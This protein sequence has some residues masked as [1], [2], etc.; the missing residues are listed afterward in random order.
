MP[1]WMINILVGFWSVLAEMSPYLLFG[2]FMAGVL[3]ILISPSLVERHLGSRGMW[4]IIK[5]AA[6]GI[7]LPLCSCGVIP[8]S[9][10]LRRHGASRGATT[11]FLISTP[12]DGVDSI[13][14]AYGLLGGVYAIFMPIV[15]LVTG[16]T[17]GILVNIVDRGDTTPDESTIDLK[18]EEERQ[19]QLKQGG[20]GERQV[21]QDSRANL[22]G[23][24][25]NKIRRIFSY[26]FITMPNDIGRALI[27]G[28]IIAALISAIIPKDY[29][30]SIVSPGFYRFLC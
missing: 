28:L 6:F 27:V 21:G 2:F 4:S 8:V 30:S 12:Q 18:G 10:S 20:E 24:I 19:Q 26:G 5:A 1:E 9:A 7:P 22:T 16:I 29:F 25:Q 15:S 14:V 23:Y 17:G 11:A 3:S 13:M